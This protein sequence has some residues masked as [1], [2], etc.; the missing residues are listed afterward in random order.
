ML[1]NVD[2]ELVYFLK[3]EALL[4]PR[5]AVLMAQ[6]T[7]KAKRF[8]ERYDCSDMSYERRYTLILEAVK[9]AMI[10]SN[11]EDG[12]R[13][14]LKNETQG[15]LRDKNAAF[16]KEGKVGHSGWKGFLGRDSTLPR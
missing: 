5:T 8:L 15:E 2:V 9:C 14:C 10:I 16:V 12:V 11:D 1:E 4:K 13:Q 7:G 3:V 6:L